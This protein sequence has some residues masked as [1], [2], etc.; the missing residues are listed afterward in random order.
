MPE[1]IGF[2]KSLTIREIGKDEYWLQDQ[3]YE[4]PN[5]LGLGELETVE[6]ERRQSSGGR[7]DI[8]LKNPE[9]DSMYEVEIMLGETDETHIIRTIEYWDNET[10]K[11]PQRQHF[12]VLV[13][14]HINRRF[15]NVIHL[16]S[17]AIPI[18]AIQASLIESYGKQSLFFTKILDTYEEIDDGTS[19]TTKT[20][21]ED[22]IKKSKWTLE[23]ADYLFELSSKVF[24]EPSLNYVK[25]YI[26]ITSS[27]NYYNYLWLH[28]RSQN[29][30]LLGF[31]LKEEMH[32]KMKEFLDENNISY[33]TKRKRFFITIDKKLVEQNKELFIKIAEFAKESRN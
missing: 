15:F 3:I 23:T 19:D 17:N 9:D 24:E 31:R 30:S 26:S 16:L 20:T 1:T 29:K 12:A 4:N 10:R 6:R 27:G 32:D 18:I 14:E 2:A 25:A 7:L 11:W 13:A 22:W 28:R 21:R 8:L 33:T 5:C